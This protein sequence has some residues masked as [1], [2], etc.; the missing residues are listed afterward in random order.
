MRDFRILSPNNCV[1]GIKEWHL[2]LKNYKICSIDSQ[3]QNSN[4]TTYRYYLIL[5]FR[6]IGNQFRPTYK[7]TDAF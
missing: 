5:F 4:A 2:L 6:R 3:F 7:Y 1:K